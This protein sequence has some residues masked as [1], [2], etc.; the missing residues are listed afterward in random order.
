M[1]DDATVRRPSSCARR[2]LCGCA[3]NV[4]VR[5]TPFD[6]DAVV[7]DLHRRHH[8]NAEFV[9]GVLAGRGQY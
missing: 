8:P 3:L 9:S 1:R 4:S 7:G 5:A 6:V 2:Q